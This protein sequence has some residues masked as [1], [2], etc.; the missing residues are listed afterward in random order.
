MSP[1]Q[2]IPKVRLR[3]AVGCIL[4]LPPLIYGALHVGSLFGWEP[5]LPYFPR[6]RMAPA[7]FWKIVAWNMP[8]AWLDFVQRVGPQ[9][10]PELSEIAL[11][12]I[13]GGITA[14]ILQVIAGKF[15]PAWRWR[16]TLAALMFPAVLFAIILSAGGAANRFAEL[17]EDKKPIDTG[18]DIRTLIELDELESQYPVRVLPE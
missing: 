6:P 11:G 1:K 7:N 5:R 17:R 14:G 4:L 8:V 10:R 3:F 2:P 13:C 18:F 12:L 15:T 9:I 16:S